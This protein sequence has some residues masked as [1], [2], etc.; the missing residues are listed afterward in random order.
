MLINRIHIHILKLSIVCVFLNCN[1]QTDKTDT[2]GLDSISQSVSSKV[3]RNPIDYLK[4]YNS[5]NNKLFAFV[6]RKVS[7]DTLP[8]RENIMDQGFKAT[9]VVLQKVFG[10]FSQDTIEF[11]AYD[12]YGIPA[13]SECDNVLLYVLSDS[14]TYYHIKYMYSEVYL[15][16]DGRWAGMYNSNNYRSENAKKTKIKPVVIDFEKEVSCPV[17]NINVNEQIVRKSYPR[18]YFKI[19]DGKLI[20]VYG[21][22]VEELFILKRDT[23]FTEIG[24]FKDGKLNE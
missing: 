22:Y 7:L 4:N 8:Y 23:Y 12:H 10:D 15:T 16:K 24:I 9:Y 14:G 3:N 1:R 5:E 2:S 6:G 13:F 19:V 20:A 11:A 17:K 21:N 18:P